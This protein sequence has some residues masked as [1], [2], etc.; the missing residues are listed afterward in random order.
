MAR[1]KVTARR[2]GKDR[3]IIGLSGPSFGDISAQ[4]VIEDIQ[5]GA[6]TYYVREGPYESQ[7]R[8]A[9]EGDERRLVSTSDLLSP[10][11]LENLPPIRGPFDRF[12]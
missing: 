3:I 2:M 1:R 6:H 4:E 10:N 9:G 11:N 8:V 5:S 7:V 12:R